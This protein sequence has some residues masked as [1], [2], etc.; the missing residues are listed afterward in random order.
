[1]KP[2]LI[3]GGDSAIGKA[4]ASR[5]REKGHKVL[6]TSRQAG[7]ASAETLHLDLSGRLDLTAWPDQFEVVYLLAAVTSLAACQSDP[8]GTALINVER[9]LELARLLSAMDAH[10]VFI[11]TN[12]VLAGD[13][14]RAPGDSP[15]APQCEYAA[16]KAEVE[17]ALLTLPNPAS[18]LRVTK[19]TSGLEGLVKDWMDSLAAGRPIHPLSDLLCAPLPVDYLL[20][21]LAGLAD[22]RVGGL[23]QI[24]AD[25]DL[26]YADI[27]RLLAN[28]L[29]VDPSLVQP[30]S[31]AEAGITLL[32]APRNTTL[33]SRRTEAALNLPPVSSRD[34][35]Y[36][37]FNRL[38]SS[39]D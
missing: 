8:I 28:H 27:A 12:L 32:A 5:L 26:S 39:S 10:L 6:A 20:S 11:S 25:Q 7:R 38:I 33:E 35:L 2:H 23:Y 1:M 31:S 15:Y 19:I 17:R 36:A 29:K 9:T 13:C 21:A 16:Q 3:V 34:S 14:P 30:K 22:R 18:V 24:S 4:L 37:L